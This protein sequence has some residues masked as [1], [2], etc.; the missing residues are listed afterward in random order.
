ME[1]RKVFSSYKV[2]VFTLLNLDFKTTVFS[3]SEDI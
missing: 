2:H 1:E 3:E